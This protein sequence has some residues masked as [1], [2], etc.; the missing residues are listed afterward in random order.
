MNT[1]IKVRIISEAFNGEAFSL[2]AA[3]YQDRVFSFLDPDGVIRCHPGSSQ[4]HVKAKPEPFT[5]VIPFQ[6]HLLQAGEWMINACYCEGLY[7]FIPEPLAVDVLPYNNNTL[8]E[9][10]CTPRS[11]FWAYVDT[12]Y[13]L[14]EVKHRYGEKYARLRDGF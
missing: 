4:V 7:L 12:K 8:M 5:L 11:S 10:T 9:I 2:S 6:G 1:K 3:F 14:L 13:H